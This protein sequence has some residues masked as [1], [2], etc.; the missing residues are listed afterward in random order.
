M[1]KISVLIPC[2]NCFLTLP[3]AV[4]S[5]VKQAGVDVEA[6]LVDDASTD[7]FTRQTIAELAAEYDNVTVVLRSEN[8]R[9]AAALN[10]GAEAASGDYLM[11][12]DSDDWLAEGALA[13]LAAVLDANAGIGFAYG[14]RRYHGRRSVVY[15]PEPYNRRAFDFHNAAGYS[16]LFRREIW[17][18][19][20]RWQA[21]GT[22]GGAVIDLEDWQHLLAMQN[23]GYRGYALTDAVTLNYCFRWN[24]TWQELQDVAPDALTALKA[25]FPSVEAVTL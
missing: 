13:R 6:V 12:V 18:S 8:G 24:G 15:L 23:A 2:H 3:R 10:S 4:R 14:G 17:D 16:Y 21:L 5:V 19:G 22:F 25:R 11:R 7:G 9:I 20:I 1:T